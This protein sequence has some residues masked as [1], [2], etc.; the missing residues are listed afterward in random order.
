MQKIQKINIVL[1]TCL[2]AVLVIVSSIFGGVATVYAATSTQYT[3]AL[4]DLKTDSSFNANDY[5]T[6]AKDYS[7]QVIQVAESTDG[8]LFVYVYQPSGQAKSLRASTI[9]ISTA[10][11]ESLSYKNYKLTYL[12]S[13]S[14]FFK[15]KVEGFTVKADAVR[16]Y[17][18]SSIYR[19]W[20]ENFDKALEN[21]NEITE[22]A[23]EVGQLWTACT[24]NDKVTYQ[25]LTSETITITDKYVGLVRYSNGFKLYV[26]KCDAHFVAFSTDRQIDKLME[27]DVYFV[28]QSKTW[29]FVT[30]V[31]ESVSY[32]DK[33]ENYAYLK[34]IDVSSNSADGLFGKKYTW[35]RIE[36]AADFIKNEDLTDEGK[37]DV[38]NKQW[39]LR[40][41]E[42]DY[43][44]SSGYGTSTE[45]STIV[46]EVT[47]LRLKFE[48]DG[49][50]YNLGVV[51]NK[52]TGDGIPDNNN[53]NEFDFS[54]I[55]STTNI[56]SLIKLVLG[57]VVIVVLLIVL[58]PIITPLISYLIKG[59]IWLVTLP[60]KLIGK[61]SKARS[62]RKANKQIKRNETNY[63]YL[64]EYD[65]DSDFWSDIDDY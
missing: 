31:G 4:T 28:T 55:G 16:Y 62:R 3:D 21:G 6:N 2:L 42:S 20:N 40:F 58:L 29:S 61:L 19:A 25:M 7:L 37:A 14:V 48:T 56:W 46:S 57:L 54:L 52:Q 60:F 11:N 50:V 10:I 8:E 38:A 44:L 15:Y 26:S 65:W 24:V 49:K 30:F 36:S 35:N 27:A 45:Y 63:D 32:G 47:I 39:V 17:D 22:V 43:S 41:Y 13:G 53:T 51:D 18:I 34:Y 9:N 12:N 1:L 33:Q 23:Y 64:D 59:I 5:P